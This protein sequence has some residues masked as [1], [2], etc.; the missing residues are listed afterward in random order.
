M[1]R[2]TVSAETLRNVW[3]KDI[4][5]KFSNLSFIGKVYKLVYVSLFKLV[6]ENP[7]V[8]LSRGQSETF[9]NIIEFALYSDRLHHS[10]EVEGVHLHSVGALRPLW[11][12]G[13]SQVQPLPLHRKTPAT[14]LP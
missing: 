3:N 8:H 14:C 12:Q 4:S 10:Q 2:S 5:I 11:L 1:S 6:K 13:T 7:P 9:A